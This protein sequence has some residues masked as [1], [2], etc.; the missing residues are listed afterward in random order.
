M[1]KLL[2][3]SKEVFKKLKAAL[4]EFGFKP[5]LA[6]V[7]PK[8][9]SRQKLPKK[10]PLVDPKSDDFKPDRDKCLGSFEPSNIFNI[11]NSHLWRLRNLEAWFKEQE[12]YED[13]RYL[14]SYSIKI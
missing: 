4:D 13:L 5:K 11:Q 3:I 10:E 14:E 8:T 9:S 12:S 7:K 1:T 6:S 2:C